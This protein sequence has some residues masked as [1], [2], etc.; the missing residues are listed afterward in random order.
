M[1]GFLLKTFFNADETGL[2][3]QVLSNKAFNL[4]GSTSQGGKMSKVHTTIL[5][6]LNM[7]GSCQLRPFMIGK[8]KSPHCMKNCKSLSTHY[9]FNRKAWVIQQ[10]FSEWLQAWD[11]S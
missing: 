6:A 2:F 5:V 9:G 8:S 3:L 10:L 1:Q 7:D 11:V 4:Q